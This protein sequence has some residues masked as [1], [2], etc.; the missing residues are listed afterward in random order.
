MKRSVYEAPR[1][2]CFQIEIEG[3]FMSASIVKGNSSDVETT[4]HEINE[5]DVTYHD[6]ND[7]TSG[8]Q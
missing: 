1:T 3:A 2:D 6:W 5:V 8:W 7:D 4:G